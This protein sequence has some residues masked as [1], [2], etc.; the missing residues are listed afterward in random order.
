MCFGKIK[1][2]KVLIGKN[3]SST[4]TCEEVIQNLQSENGALKTSVADLKKKAAEGEQYS[5]SNCLE[6]NGVPE[7]KS[8]N[9]IVVVKQIANA[10]NFK[11]EDAM[12]DAV[13]R[14]SKNPSKPRVPRG[15]ILRFCRRIDMEEMRQRARV[16][17]SI[18]AADLGY[19]TEGRIYVNLSLG[20]ETHQLWAQVRKFKVDHNYKYAWITSAG[21]IYLRRGE[22]A[23]AVH[24]SEVSDLDRIN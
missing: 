22:S 2:C 8:E 12:I 4:T 13:H 9:I 7:T 10:L 16:K 17:K 18:N 19:Q 15:I 14:L 24:I 6:I 11:L 20:R 21:K 5:R 1:D 3:S 23:N